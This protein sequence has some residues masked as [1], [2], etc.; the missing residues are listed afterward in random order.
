MFRPHAF[1]FFHGAEC[2]RD[3]SVHKG[4]SD[5][6]TILGFYVADIRASTFFFVD[7]CGSIRAPYVLLTFLN[8]LGI[9]FFSVWRC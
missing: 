7:A 3:S 4:A 9:H 6:Y 5:S 8:F 2:R 1:F